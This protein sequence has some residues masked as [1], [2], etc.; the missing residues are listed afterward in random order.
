MSVS[1]RREMVRDWL[2]FAAG[3]AAVF[4]TLGVVRRVQFATS[5]AGYGDSL[6]GGSAVLAV[7]IGAAGLGWLL[8]VKRDRRPFPYLLLSNIG[9]AYFLA[10]STLADVPIARIHLI[11]YGVLALLAVRAT[12]HH[13]G[14]W[15]AYGVAMSLVFDAGFLDEV[16]QN[17]IPSR[18]YDPA[19]VLA[20]G[21]AGLLGLLAVMVGRW[22]LPAAG[23]GASRPGPQDTV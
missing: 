14:T 18:V 16:I 11:E 17:F 21:V 6:A 20:N 15:L 22:P 10:L 4:A 23:P 9:V 1:S 3:V 13:F 7:L 2:A 12:R 19:D 5:R 8:F